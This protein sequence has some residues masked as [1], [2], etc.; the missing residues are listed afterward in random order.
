M[1]RTPASGF[2]E[3]A[4]GIP[5]LFACT[6]LIALLFLAWP[7]A[8]SAMVL[9]PDSGLAQPVGLLGESHLRCDDSDE[10]VEAI[11]KAGRAEE[12]QPLHGV[13]AKGFTRKT[14]WLRFTLQRSP[15]APHEWWLEV[16][17]PY[18]DE[19]TL[20]LGRAGTD[21]RIM[22]LGDH[23]AF[24]ARPI[25][26][27]LFVFPVHLP[28]EKPVTAYLR[29]RTT[30]TMLVETLNVW[31]PAGLLASAHREAAW[32][33]GVFGL[34]ALGALS[35]LVFWWWLRERIYCAYTAY[36]VSLLFLNI[37]NSGFG[38]MWL[39][40]DQPVVADRS[41]G[42]AVGL[43][44]LTGL[45]FF[46]QVFALRQNFPRL[47]RGIPWILA[48]YGFAILAAVTGY[49][50]QVAAPIQVLA[51]LVTLGI[52]FAGPWLIG[53]GH[54]HL[55]LY[56]AAF[57]FQLALVVAAF[58][59]NLGL[60]PLEISIDH[61]VL[62]ASG[63]HVVLLNIALA[64]RMRNIQREQQRLETEAA[65]LSAELLAL[66]QQR[67]FMAM[68]AH[69]FRTP[70]AIVDTSIQV[71]AS[72]L[73]EGKIDQAE[74]CTN[75]RDAVRRITTLIDEF[76]TRERMEEA[77]DGFNPDDVSL[78]TLL[79]GVLAGLPP[80]R[81][82]IEHRQVVQNLYIDFHLIQVALTNLL[83][84]ALRYSPPSMKVRLDVVGR[85]DGGITFVVSDSGMGIPLD[86]QE[87]IFDKYFRGRQAKTLVGAGL[88]LYLVKRIASL[89]GGTIELESSPGMGC[90]FTLSLP[91]RCTSHNARVPAT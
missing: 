82:Q 31:Q 20:I 43:S 65:R 23:Q 48:S 79:E 28:D 66:D 73:K 84:N 21:A 19:V 6:W 81:I 36:L 76:L 35:N 5:R 58:T 50:G 74:R 30:S 77:S 16:G 69:E 34:M 54:T 78:D 7:P 47:G 38:A 9:T 67:E 62:G 40:P 25:A 4:V 91:G 13:L 80:E 46:E 59:R 39:F 57:S 51:L 83:N 18:L 61:F 89:H 86:E 60:W 3:V 2:R 71:M 41:I 32:Y 72:Q 26:H 90:R 88:G 63:L 37:M 27:R 75:I 1:N 15:D 68:V 22:A 29:I 33:W 14:C 10:P 45:W 11:T 53:Q 12:F 87:R 49:W 55:R 52:G 24:S 17:M 70:L 44:L 8:L 64:N 42:F 85:T 56:V